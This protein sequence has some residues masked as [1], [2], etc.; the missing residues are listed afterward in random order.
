MADASSGSR[1]QAGHAGAR[2]RGTAP[3]VK[4]QAHEETSS[5]A[6]MAR[7]VASSAVQG[8]KDVASSVAHRAEGMASTIGHRAEEAVG[9]IG[10]EMRALAG[11]IRESAP[12]G[13]VVGSAASGMA[14]TL[15][16]GGAYLQEH[17]LR[18]MGEDVTNV[19][20]RYPL[21][22]ILLGIGVGF[23]VGRASRS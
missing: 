21:Q 17:N 16:S 6:A 7:E 2:E 13:G 5:L 23:L 12:Q 3:G 11:T 9:A 18:G 4:G 14:G 19:V 20:R 22:A 10:G 15:E 8:T 1:D